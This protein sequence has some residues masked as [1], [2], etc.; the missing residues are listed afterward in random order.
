[1]TTS[2]KAESFFSRGVLAIFGE[3]TDDALAISRDVTG[4]ILVQRFHETYHM[5][6]ILFGGAVV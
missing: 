6:R 3:S 1:M 2:A 5:G 4:N